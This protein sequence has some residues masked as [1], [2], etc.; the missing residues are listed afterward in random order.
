ME[1]NEHLIYVLSNSI[2]LLTYDTLCIFSLVTISELKI[3][4]SKTRLN[5]YFIVF[6]DIPD[7]EIRIKT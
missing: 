2:L 5:N 4:R 6:A 3:P 1:M 7:G